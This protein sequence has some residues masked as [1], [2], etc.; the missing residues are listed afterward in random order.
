MRKK[1]MKNHKWKNWTAGLLSV[2]LTC[3]YP[4]VFLFAQNA[5]E[6]RARDMLPFFLLFLGTAAVGMLVCGAIFRN[7]SRAAFFSS[8]S[9]LVVINFT[10]ITG[11][12]KGK[13]PWFQ[14]KMFLLLVGVVLLALLVL[15][16]RKKPNMTAGCAILSLTFGALCVMSLI[17]AAPK[18][19]MTA[20]MQKEAE[21]QA[22]SVDVTL[23]G[24]KRNVYY[25]IFDE[26]GGDENLE[27]YFG[28]DNSAFYA[29]LEERG[30]S[31]SRDSYNTESCWTDTLIPNMLN[32]DYVADDHMPEKVRRDFLK[33]PLLFQIFRKNG[34]AINLINHRAYLR[35]RTV[36]ELTQGQTEDNISEYLFKNS[37]YCKIPVIKDRINL[38]L[39][40]N[41]RDHYRG[42]LENALGVLIKS[43]DYAKNGPT[44]TVSYIQC[45]HAPFV[46]RL[47][48]RRN[49]P[50]DQ[51]NWKKQTQYPEQLQCL[52]QIILEAVD[53]IQREDPEAVILLQSDHGA[54]VPLHMVEQFG[55]PRF[56]AEK[57]TPVM[58]NALC[59]AYIP[60]ETVDIAGDTC[61]NAARKVLN[62]AFGTELSTVEPK[63]G[64]V[65]DDIYNAHP[66]DGAEEQTETSERS[67]E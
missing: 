44:L 37:I 30:F 59:C 41:Y 51:W 9:M 31:V 8:V 25:L 52:N 64:Y 50:E 26:Y 5:G 43:S 29:A 38:W 60:G 14:D 22:Q 67:E 32:L 21:R 20:S 63:T 55:G 61:I 47:D 45:P 58:Q 39:F 56:D 34:Y 42:P 4:C 40:E 6:A 12:I 57:E 35:D 13:L 49:P 48:G 36:N 27:T 65:L 66:G 54:R 3:L 23:S 24:E 33:N 15:L 19:F 16:L 46:L 11:G 53:N 62:T 17:N 10:M 28:F 2:V 18:L 7:V 1:T